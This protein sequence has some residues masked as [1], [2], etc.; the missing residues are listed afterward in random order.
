[1]AKRL[2]CTLID[3]AQTTIIKGNIEAWFWLKVILIIMY[4]KYLRL[5]STFQGLSFHNG[6]HKKLPK[7][8]HLQ[9]LRSTLYVLIYKKEQK[10]MKEKF[11]P[12]ALRDKLV[13]FDSHI[14]SCIY[15]KK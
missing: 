6:L 12:R 10:L 8:S 5:I 4:T 9:I 11:V 15:I 1:M 2:E 13:R 14:I 7:L 3:M